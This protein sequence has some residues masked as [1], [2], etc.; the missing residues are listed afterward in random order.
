[1]VEYQSMCVLF[2]C[3]AVTDDEL[4]LAIMEGEV[5]TTPPGSVQ[6]QLSSN[7]LPETET[8]NDPLNYNMEETK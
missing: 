1:M 8:E 4:S 6:N 5:V 2:V 3:T 7:G